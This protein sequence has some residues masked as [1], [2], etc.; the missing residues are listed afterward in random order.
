[1]PQQALLAAADER[2]VGTGN[3][4]RGGDVRRVRGEKRPHQPALLH[5]VPAIIVRGVLHEL[6]GTVERGA[7][8]RG[9][10]VDA[11]IRDEAATAVVSAAAAVTRGARDAEC[12]SEPAADP[13]PPRHVRN[14]A[15]PAL[16]APLP[17]TDTVGVSDARDHPGRVSGRGRRGARRPS[18][19]PSRAARRAA[20]ARQLVHR[21]RA[22]RDRGREPAR[23][24]LRAVCRAQGRALARS[25]RAAST[26]ALR[27][28]P[29]SPRP[30]SRSRT[31]CA[32][33]RAASR[34]RGSSARS[35][36]G[37]RRGPT[38]RSSAS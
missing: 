24:G 2:P 11:G 27:R 36:P 20:P 21:C 3:V 14:I 13:P 23:A 7:A 31:A 19:L 1:M 35:R 29:V 9:G 26:S 38:S 17:P 8:E 28:E 22:D 34:A 10:E 12:R 16:T 18:R 25:S 4:G 15:A 37:S 30:S 6:H 32:P 5:D 33:T